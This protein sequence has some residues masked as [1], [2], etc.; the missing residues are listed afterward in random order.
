MPATSHHTRQRSF[1]RFLVTLSLI[2]SA[3]ACLLTAALFKLNSQATDK[4]E[5]EGK[6]RRDQTCQTL[7]LQYRDNLYNLQATYRY[8]LGLSEEQAREA[9]NA[10]IALELPR[11][12]RRVLLSRPPAYCSDPGVGL[13]GRT[14]SVPER[15]VELRD[16]SS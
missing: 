3:G 6:E 15:P 8:L 5:A 11:T 16:R 4:I 14:P 1:W 7:E 12:E 2:T 10:A 9:I 13:P